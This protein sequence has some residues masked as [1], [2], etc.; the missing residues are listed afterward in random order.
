M[1]IFI[2]TICIIFSGCV[3]ESKVNQSNKSVHQG[4]VNVTPENLS[5][6]N[7]SREKKIPEVEVKSF[8]SIHMH[9]NS[10]TGYNIAER[11]YAVYGL[12]IKNNGSNNLNFK[13]NKLHVRDGD[14]IF[15]TTNLDTTDFSGRSKLD[16]L[17]DLEKENIIGNVTLSPGQT[18]NGSVV[19]QVNSLY[20]ESFLLMY[21]ETSI[22]STSIGKS[23]E[24]LR[25]A[26]RYNYSVAFA[27]PPYRNINVDSFEPNLEVYPYI[28]PNWVNRSIFE[29]FDR[30]DSEDVLR[31]TPNDKHLS[32]IVY[33]LKVIPERN[34]TIL[35]VKPRFIVVDDTGEELINTSEIEKISVLRN[36]AYKMNLS[37]VTFV[38]T[39][40]GRFGHLGIGIY[41]YNNQD[42]IMDDYQNI[43]LVRR[44]NIGMHAP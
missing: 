26:E 35:S 40:F 1:L 16:I 39:S 15:N 7:L 36:E 30:V 44:S 14:Y 43:I 3:E 20:N 12:S 11:C 42:V 17:S 31:S 9:D 23:I 24:A 18:I 21:N 37:N 13:L 22:T 19:F 33:A 2:L 5:S 32:I 29:F 34:I 10:E 6:K 41:C 38:R 25:T 4:Q 28:F 8:S 27:I